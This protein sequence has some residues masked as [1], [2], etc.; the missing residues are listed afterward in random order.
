M[1]GWWGF[2]VHLLRSF[3]PMWVVGVLYLL[4]MPATGSPSF[5]SLAP[6]QQVIG[7]TALPSLLWSL[8]R[9]DDG[10]D[11]AKPTPEERVLGDES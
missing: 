3:I 1:T 9:F 6:H 4:F 11:D 8:Y 2:A 10:L 5:W 7:A